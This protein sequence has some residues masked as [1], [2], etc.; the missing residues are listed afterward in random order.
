[1]MNDWTKFLIFLDKIFFPFLILG[2]SYDW[3]KTE[4]ILF[5]IR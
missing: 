4:S 1:V 5:N 2:F 3:Q